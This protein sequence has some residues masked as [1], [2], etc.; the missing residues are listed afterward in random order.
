MLGRFDNCPLQDLLR[1][2]LLEFFGDYDED[3]QIIF[4]QWSNT[5]RATLLPMVSDAPSFVNRLIDSLEELRPY[6]FISKAQSRYLN[7]LKENLNSSRAM[8]LGNFA[9]NF[10]FIVQDEI[11]E[12]SCVL[13]LELHI[14]FLEEQTI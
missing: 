14:Y 1:N 2:H 3:H 12:L 6:S 5:D 7:L 9:E 10:S 13:L 4:T 8:F 11:T